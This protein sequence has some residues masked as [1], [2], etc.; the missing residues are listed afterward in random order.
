M[1]GAQ[2]GTG[3]RDSRTMPWAQ[4]SAKLLSHPGIPEHGA[5]HLTDGE[6]EAQKASLWPVVKQ[7]E[8]AQLG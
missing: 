6:N 3:S 2:H 1:Q 5:S 4:G 8:S 7:W